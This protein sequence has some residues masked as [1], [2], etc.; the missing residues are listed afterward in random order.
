MPRRIELELTSERP[1]GTWTWRAAGAREP[2]G[3]LESSILPQGVKVGDV[4]RAEA[5]ITIDGITVLS[6]LPPKGG[7]SE[8]ERI[9]IIG[10][11]RE[12]TPVTSTLVGRAEGRD[13]GPR[14]EGRDRP[15]RGGR[16]DRPDRAPR[17]DRP[18]RGDR[19]ARPHRE[20]RP[21]RPRPEGAERPR[22]ERAAPPPPKP[23]PKK[24]RPSRAH[25]DALMA[26]LSPEQLAIAEQ[27]F[28][29]GMPSVRQAVEEQN[30]KAALEGLPEMPSATVLAIAEDLL[31][32]VRVADWL[33][34]AEAAIADA[35]EIALRDLRAVVASSD[36]VARD[37]ST[38]ELASRLREVLERRSSA[39]QDEWLRDL[40]ASLK[41][42][43]VVR[44]L[45]L[46]SRP[47][48]PGENVPEDIGSEL[49]AAAGAAMSSDITPDRWATLLDAVA[50]SPIRRTIAPAGAPPEPTEELLTMVRKHAGR[51]PTA[52]ALFGIEPPP[53]P[54]PKRAARAPRP[55]PKPRPAKASHPPLPPLPGGGRRIPPPPRP[56]KAADPVSSA[57]PGEVPASAVADSPHP[58][59]DELPTDAPTDAP[60][61]AAPE[62]PVA[63]D[64][65]DVAP[66]TEVVE[67]AQVVPD[68]DAP[69]GDELPADAPTFAPADESG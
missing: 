68:H 45:R 17:S 18:D 14:R 6:V 40:R 9:E 37:E 64:E 60:T 20:D 62:A 53:P 52:A 22:P 23:K 26:A 56:T 69:G 66:G 34:R 3:E 2:R 24:L 1:D 58:H 5:D 29:G 54:A 32:R 51:V 21:R 47:P 16:P 36:D 27:L 41:D 59:G 46:S 65:A 15:D 61:A 48:Q 10:P 19:T 50:Y 4:L 7:R 13:R 42:G 33:D 55:A 67:E 25:R 43:R 12:F 38:R 28:R 8:P 30:A 31:P 35:E 39:E 11:Q 49:A 63:V 57:P 44:A